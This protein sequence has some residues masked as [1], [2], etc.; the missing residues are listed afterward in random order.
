MMIIEVPSVQIVRIQEL[1][2]WKNLL[3]STCWNDKEK[4]V[5]KNGADLEVNY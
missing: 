5:V 4:L 2:Y 3:G 1:V